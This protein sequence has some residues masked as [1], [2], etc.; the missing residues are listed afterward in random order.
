MAAL[1][2]SVPAA[3]AL[4]CPD[5]IFGKR[6]GARVAV[7]RGPRL[8]PAHPISRLGHPASPSLSPGATPID[9][10][11]VKSSSPE[12]EHCPEPLQRMHNAVHYGGAD[13]RCRA[14]KAA[15]VAANFEQPHDQE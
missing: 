5:D 14:R 9:D 8:P 13:F 4:T 3:K 2:G 7:Q 1:P 10:Q 11:Q 12:N 6:K 15:T